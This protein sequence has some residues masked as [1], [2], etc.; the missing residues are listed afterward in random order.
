MWSQWGLSG[1]RR[2]LG[3]EARGGQ[4]SAYVDVHVGSVVT[5]ETEWGLRRARV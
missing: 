4:G 1:V 3:C 5:I 2:G